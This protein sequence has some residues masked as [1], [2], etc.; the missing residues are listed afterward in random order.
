MT[1]LLNAAWIASQNPQQVS[2]VIT[3]PIANYS[4]APFVLTNNV[5]AT[6]TNQISGYKASWLWISLLLAVSSLLLVC[7]ACNMILSAGF[8]TG[9]EILGR[10]STLTRDSV[11]FPRSAGVGSALDGWQRAR[12]LQHINI[13]LADVAPHSEVGRIAFTPAEDETSGVNGFH[14]R[15]GLDKHSNGRIRK[16]RC[17]PDRTKYF[18]IES[19]NKSLHGFYCAKRTLE[20]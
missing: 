16:G 20:L 9:P 6:I 14:G 17:I 10:V 5:T 12:A 18:P 11:Q 2:G 3:T 19:K 1:R 7:A 15:D 8:I 13:Q 4:S